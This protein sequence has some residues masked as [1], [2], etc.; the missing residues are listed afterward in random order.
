MKRTQLEFDRPETLA[1]TRPAEARG[2]ERDEVRLLVSTPSGHTH[3]YFRDLPMF[4]RPGDLLVVNRSATL[5]ASALGTWACS[6]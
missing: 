6:R 1:A 2:I 5:P 4:L 3:A